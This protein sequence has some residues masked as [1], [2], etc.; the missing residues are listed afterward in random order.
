MAPR[1]SNR[2]HSN[3]PIP[4]KE[5]DVKKNPQISRTTTAKL[6]NGNTNSKIRTNARKIQINPIR[7]NRLTRE[8][9][10]CWSNGTISKCKG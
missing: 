6:H 1:I 9:I 4:L 2:A 10:S 5:Y 7:L 8:I 3:P